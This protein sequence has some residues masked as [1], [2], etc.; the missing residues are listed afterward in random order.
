VILREPG[1]HERY[2]WVGC[3]GRGAYKR[4]H[5]SLVRGGGWAVVETMGHLPRDEA[6]L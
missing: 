4:Y 5:G 3:E 6:G 2:P 1:G